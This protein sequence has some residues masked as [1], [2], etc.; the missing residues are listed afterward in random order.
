MANFFSVIV[1]SCLVLGVAFASAMDMSI[2][3]YEVV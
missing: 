1:V 2:I 3:D